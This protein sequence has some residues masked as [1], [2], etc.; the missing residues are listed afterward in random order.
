MLA[1]HFFKMLV[2][3]RQ[4][5]LKTSKCWGASRGPFHYFTSS[6]SHMLCRRWLYTGTVFLALH[7]L[8]FLYLRLW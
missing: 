6:T 1:Q 7:F 4:S 2:I 5:I 8:V 3:H